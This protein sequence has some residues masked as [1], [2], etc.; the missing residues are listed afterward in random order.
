[1]SSTIAGKQTLGVASPRSIKKRAEYYGQFGGAASDNGAVIS[2]IEKFE[3]SKY[4]NKNSH[5]GKKKNK[6]INSASHRNVDAV[7]K[8][9]QSSMANYSKY[10]KDLYKSIDQM[11]LQRAQSAKP[12]KIKG[13]R[14]QFKLID[15]GKY[16]D[17]QKYGRFNW[18]V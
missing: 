6:R 11:N 16:H 8:Q 5:D 9:Q 10:T 15:L 17:M 14:Y 3:E 1:M 12:V 2:R 13:L 18:P 4:G 7:Q